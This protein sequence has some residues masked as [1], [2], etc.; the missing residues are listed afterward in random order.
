MDSSKNIPVH[1]TSERTFG[2]DPDQRVPV[3][4][5][6]PLAQRVKDKFYEMAPES[7]KS[8]QTQ[9]QI[10]QGV[11]TAKERLTEAFPIF[12]DATR[13]ENREKISKFGNTVSLV[14]NSI[15]LVGTMLAL[16]GTALI[17]GKLGWGKVKKWNRN[18]KFKKYNQYGNQYGSS[19]I[20]QRSDVHPHQ[21]GSLGSSLSN[22]GQKLTP[23]RFGDQNQSYSQNRW[24]PQV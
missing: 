2:R 12:G 15:A 11:D 4:Q 6:A 9:H 18:R 10:R 17:F 23:S 22:L 21:Q 7:L 19:G 24:Q 14:G 20:G 5:E 13:P 1:D 3:G 8:G 16:T